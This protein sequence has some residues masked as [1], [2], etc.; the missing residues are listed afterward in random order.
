MKQ[1]FEGEVY[2]ILPLSN[3]ILFSYCKDLTE[4]N[5]IIIG[6]KM[7]SFD[8]GR[9]T[10]ITKNVYLATK[11]G[12]NYNSVINHCDN[13]ITT[14]AILFPSG[15]TLLFLKDGITKLIDTDSTVAW[16][17]KLTYRSFAASDIIIHK[18]SL[19]A[20]FSD[21]NVLLRYNLNNMRE[22]LRIGGKSSPF[23]MP[24]S[25]F[26]EDDIVTVCN[27]GSKKLTKVNLESYI[28]LEDQT[29]EEQV[30]QY[31]KSDIYQFVILTSGLYI[32]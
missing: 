21:C 18:N 8:N 19:W 9:M 16:Q 30:I 4:D 11:F 24:K 17:G 3:G 25:M 5:N 27:K 22:E 23:D 2:E 14:K 32:L 1:I 10:D 29:F 12:N 13:Y 28:V 31:L 7:I 6:Y 15:K 20:C 26:L